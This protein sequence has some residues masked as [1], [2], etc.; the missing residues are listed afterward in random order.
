MRP[1]QCKTSA[2]ACA[3][4][5]GVNEAR[6]TL[7]SIISEN[8]DRKLYD[9]EMSFWRRAEEIRSERERLKRPAKKRAK[10]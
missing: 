3:V 5:E 8:L 6:V 2:Q 10:R 7:Y 9:L 1:D 4:A